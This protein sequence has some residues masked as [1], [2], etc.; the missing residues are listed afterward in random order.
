MAISEAVPHSD[1]VFRRDGVGDYAVVFA[2]GILDDQYVWKAVIDQLTASEFETVTFD[3]AGFGER[4]EAPG[5]Y[6]YDR[7]AADLA[8]VVD[9]LDK[10]FVLVGHSMSAPVVEL[11][12]ASRPDRAMGVILLS[13]IP[14]GGVKLPEEAIEPLRLFGELGAAELEAA[15]IQFAPSAPADEVKRIATV[16]A[17]VRPEVVRAVTDMWNNGYPG[18][19]RASEVSCP[20][21][22]LPAANEALVS[23]ELL[24]SGVVGRFGAGTTVTEIDGASHWSHLDSSAAV[25]VEIDRFLASAAA[26]RELGAHSAA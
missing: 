19:A 23:G 8:S 2:H 3:V 17:N 21:L 12:A 15:R 1:I 18:G 13:P 24:A 14:M 7:L 22:I 25:A 11:V 10:P 20:V 16:A 5:P 6:T 4:T 9:A 26:G